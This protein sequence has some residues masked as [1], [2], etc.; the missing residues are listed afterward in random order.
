LNAY[1]RFRSVPKKTRKPFTKAGRLGAQVL[2]EYALFD[3]GAFTS[4]KDI[5]PALS[6]LASRYHELLLHENDD[7]H[8]GLWHGDLFRGLMWYYHLHGE[9]RMTRNSHF[10]FRNHHDFGQPRPNIPSWSP[11]GQGTYIT[12]RE[13][14]EA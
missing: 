13:L 1:R 5:M 7:F 9:V 11:I 14:Y 6:G 8:A 4:S 3:E 10:A 12:Y 2:V